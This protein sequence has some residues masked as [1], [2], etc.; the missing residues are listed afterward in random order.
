MAVDTTFNQ[1]KG[2]NGI[3]KVSNQQT[4]TKPEEK[5]PLSKAV[6]GASLVG[7][8]ALASVG[9]YLA[10]KGKGKVKPQEVINET[11][12][13]TQQIIR[14]TENLN[15]AKIDSDLIKDENLAEVTKNLSINILDNSSVLTFS[16]SFGHSLYK[17]YLTALSKCKSSE[18]LSLVLNKILSAEHKVEP[19][20]LNFAENNKID[21]NKVIEGFNKNAENGVK[22]VAPVNATPQEKMSLILSE[23]IKRAKGNLRN[24]ICT[25]YKEPNQEILSGDYEAII[26][27]VNQRLDWLKPQN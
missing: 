2:V 9:I 25:N 11:K 12:N 7:L 6:V 8:A 13:H 18:E 20:A 16:R 14:E 19:K 27:T 5:K 21:M 17:Q 24:T 1:M 22:I 4:T 26:K 15:I 3:N 10:T 23:E